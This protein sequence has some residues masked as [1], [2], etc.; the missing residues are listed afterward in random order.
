[1]NLSNRIRDV[2]DAAWSAMRDYAIPTTFVMLLV[3]MR[4][5][6]PVS[7]FWLAVAILIG[8]VIWRVIAAEHARIT[9]KQRLAKYESL[10]RL[11]TL[12]STTR[13]EHFSWDTVSQEYFVDFKDAHFSVSNEGINA[14][15]KNQSCT[16]RTIVGDSPVDFAALAFAATYDLGGGEKA[17]AVDAVALDE[18]RKFQVTLSF[19]GAVVKPGQAVKLSYSCRWPNTVARNDDYLVFTLRQFAHPVGRLLIRTAFPVLP[20]SY[21]LVWCVIQMPTPAACR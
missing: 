6:L 3:K 16:I 20:I 11:M 5:E 10:I 13:D 17:A 19:P 7:A 12:S 1:M 21:H 15:Y 18:G 2:G 8:Y 4:K 14:S 9:V